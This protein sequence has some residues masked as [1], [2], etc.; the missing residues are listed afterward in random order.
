MW[1]ASPFPDRVQPRQHS[2]HAPPTHA[3]FLRRDRP[4]RPSPEFVYTAARCPQG[5]LPSLTSLQTL[6]PLPHSPLKLLNTG[7]IPEIKR[8]GPPLF[9]KITGGVLRFQKVR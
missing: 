4:K 3:P 2:R 5:H 1:P 6:S 7:L 9:D 8:N